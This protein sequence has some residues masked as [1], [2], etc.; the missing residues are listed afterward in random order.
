MVERLW[1]ELLKLP[2]L[3]LLGRP[4][5]SAKLDSG[6]PMAIRT[7]QEAHLDK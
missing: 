4:R 7:G 3:L 5:A 2:R 6:F 1:I